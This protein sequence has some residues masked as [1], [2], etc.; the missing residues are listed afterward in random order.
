MKNKKIL[1]GVLAFTMMLAAGCA[2]KEEAEN[3]DTASVT[4]DIAAETTASDADDEPEISENADLTSSEKP[5]SDEE[6]SDIDIDPD[7]GIDLEEPEEETP[8]S[9]EELKAVQELVNKYAEAAKI[10]DYETLVTLTNIDM[11]HY[12]S[13]G[14]D[15]PSNEDLVKA[16]KGELDDTDEAS[17]ISEPDYSGM[18]FGEPRCYNSRASIYNDFLASDSIKAFSKADAASKYKI[19]GLYS[20]KMS[21]SSDTQN[22]ENAFGFS[23]NIDMDVHVF[24]INGE[25]KVDTGYGMM[26]DI[27]NAFSSM[28]FDSETDE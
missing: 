19:D 21:G 24:R 17:L 26:V 28:S 5:V 14:N 22:E 27:F 20:F 13:T 6:I 23:S 15:S 18:S 9:E 8:A 16:L 3:N 25:W 12:I 11:L 10:N 4:E 2:E 7:F 1:A